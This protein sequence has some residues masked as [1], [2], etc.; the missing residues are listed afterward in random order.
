M[1]GEVRKSM[2]TYFKNFLAAALAVVSIVSL[3]GCGS[4]Q[5]ESQRI[6]SLIAEREANRERA[7][8]GVAQIKKSVE[9]RVA[10]NP[11]AFLALLALGDAAA[12]NFEGDVAAGQ[13]VIGGAY[14]LFNAQ[15]CGSLAADLQE[16]AAA[17]E[18]LESEAAILTREIGRLQTQLR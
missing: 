12:K 15:E 5:A 18:R 4:V 14:C 2:P 16:F 7:L 11:W 3:A 6:G 9:A 13:A 17:R 1:L 8:A 10:R